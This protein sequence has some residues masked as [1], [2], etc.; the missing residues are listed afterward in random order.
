M[1]LR[2]CWYIFGKLDLMRILTRVLCKLALLWSLR[3]KMNDKLAG[4]VVQAVFLKII[5]IF[6]LYRAYSI[7]RVYT[8]GVFL[9][10]CEISGFSLC[11]IVPDD[12]FMFFDVFEG[13]YYVSAMFTGTKT[14]T[15]LVLGVYIYNSTRGIVGEKLF[16]IYMFS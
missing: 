3:A 11:T 10:I 4:T 8:Y 1:V 7:Y 14:G 5:F 12:V 2:W 9:G 16:F 13:F 6:I 15:I